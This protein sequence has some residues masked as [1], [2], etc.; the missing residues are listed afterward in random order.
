M[1]PARKQSKKLIHQFEAH[2]NR[3]ALEADLGK[4]QAFDPFSEKSKDMIRGMGNTGTSKCARSLPKYSA[5]TVEHS[6]RQALKTLLA[7][8]ACDFQTKIAN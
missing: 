6:G 7:Q 8:H 2:P 4:D 5:T 1:T 3:E